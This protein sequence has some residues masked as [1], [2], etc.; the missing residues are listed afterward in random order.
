MN[1]ERIYGYL[2][3]M[4]GN[5]NV[6]EGRNFLRFAVYAVVRVSPSHLIHYR[7]WEGDL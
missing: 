4:V 7:D 5:M 6:N 1:E 3:R 2:V